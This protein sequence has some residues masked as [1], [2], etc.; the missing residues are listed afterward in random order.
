MSVQL[1]DRSE[2]T[3]GELLVLGRDICAKSKGSV[4]IFPSIFSHEVKPITSGTRWSLISW[5][6]GPYW[7]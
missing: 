1:T 5:A 2:Y 3:G 4:T 7:K 6:W